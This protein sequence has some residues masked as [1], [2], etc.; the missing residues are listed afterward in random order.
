[1][2]ETTGELTI[3]VVD[4]DDDYIGIEIRASNGRFAG[5]ARIYAGLDQLSALAE[6]ISGF[7]ASPSDGR[8]YQFGDPG[9]SAAAGHVTLRFRCLDL[10]GHAAVEIAVQDKD[11]LCGPERAS[12]SFRVE[13]AGIDRFATMLRELES[14]R[15]G[16][17]VLPSVL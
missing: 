11:G 12:L 2:S 7:P 17:A 8:M 14:S 16:E 4:P 13:A 15:Y 1:M 9:R 10:S 5:S 6:H 3:K